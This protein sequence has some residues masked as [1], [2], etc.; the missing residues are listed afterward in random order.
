MSRVIDQRNRETERLD[1]PCGEWIEIYTHLTAGE[2]RRLKN[3]GLKYSIKQS[4]EESKQQAE[5]SIDIVEMDFMKVLTR[6]A[7]W[8]LKSPDGYALQINREN[9][10]ASVDEELFDEMLAAID[11]FSTEQQARKNSQSPET[12]PGARMKSVGAG[13]TAPT[14]S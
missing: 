1:L 4:G 9:L 11:A 6:I 10:D 12:P 8:S 14:S 3:A 13:S 2:S 7:R 5:A